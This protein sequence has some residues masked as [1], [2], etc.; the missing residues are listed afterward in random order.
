MI[1][2]LILISLTS[3]MFSGC[4]GVIGKATGLTHSIEGKWAGE[5][6]ENKMEFKALNSNQKQEYLAYFK[7]NCMLEEEIKIIKEEYKNSKKNQEIF[8]NLAKDKGYDYLT[9]EHLEGSTGYFWNKLVKTKAEAA[10]ICHN[11]F[12]KEHNIEHTQTTEKA[13]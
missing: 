11:K 13:N 9:L 3:F 6:E 4:L 12:F 8:V 1:K 5:N 2:N 7:N 10:V